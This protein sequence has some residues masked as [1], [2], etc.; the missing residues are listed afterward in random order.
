MIL[1]RS[2]VALSR[3]L[4]DLLHRHAIDAV[5]REQDLGSSFDLILGEIAVRTRRRRLAS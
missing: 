4:H 2:L 1:Q 3:R 5:S